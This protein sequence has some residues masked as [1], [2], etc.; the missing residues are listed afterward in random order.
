M[1]SN[2]LSNDMHSC[3]YS[4]KEMQLI[5]SQISVLT[6]GYFGNVNNYKNFFSAHHLLHF[7]DRASYDTLSAAISKKGFSEHAFYIST[8]KRQPNQRVF[9]TNGLDYDYSED[10]HNI[11]TYFN[12]ERLDERNLLMNLWKECILINALNNSV[13]NS[14]QSDFEM[15]PLKLNYIPKQI[16]YLPKEK[17]EEILENIQKKADLI[18]TPKLRWQTRSRHKRQFFADDL[19]KTRI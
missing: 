2:E 16:E 18:E 5:Q 17:S 1:I 13:I 19:Q 9:I 4:K 11:K 10:P 7:Q 14:Q 12:T 6:I 15:L 3:G 8:L